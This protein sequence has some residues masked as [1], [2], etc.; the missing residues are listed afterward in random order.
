MGS[1][2][3]EPQGRYQPTA[4]AERR[5]LLVCDEMYIACDVFPYRV[6]G[7]VECPEIEAISCVPVRA[8]EKV[9]GVENSET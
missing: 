1:A 6:L 7:G 4:E 9:R 2:K 5:T 8:V 3:Y